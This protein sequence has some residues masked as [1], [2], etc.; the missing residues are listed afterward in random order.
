MP[1]E[2]E[3]LVSRAQVLITYSIAGCSRQVNARNKKPAYRLAKMVL[4]L[5]LRAILRANRR[6]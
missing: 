5:V 4:R 1:P 3:D 2:P 6:L